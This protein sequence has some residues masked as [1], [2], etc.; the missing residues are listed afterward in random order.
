V[1]NLDAIA[2]DAQAKENEDPLGSA[3]LYGILADTLAEANFPSQAAAQRRRQAQLLQAGGDSAGAFAVL[4]GMARADFTAGATSMLGP[5]QHG[6]EALRPALDALQA[7]KLDVLAAAQS[8]YERGS[9]LAVAVPALETVAAAADPDAAFLACV[10]LEQALVDG[11]FDFDP[12]HSLATPNGNTADLLALLRQC[13]DGLSCGDVV[14][15]ARLACAL[16]DSGLTVYSTAADTD[17]A[18]RPILQRAGA[19]RYLPAG[20]LVFA[21]GAPMLACLHAARTPPAGPGVRGGEPPSGSGRGLP[22]PPCTAS[23]LDAGTVTCGLAGS[24]G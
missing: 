15:R 23:E 16:A 4:W 6:M 21:R 1:L 5:V 10:T 14:I 17:A 12:P 13:A 8:W 9:Q 7:A 22:S 20:G 18:Y 11:W 3:R 19:G 24:A 2:S